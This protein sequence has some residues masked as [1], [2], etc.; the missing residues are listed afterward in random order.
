MH[1]SVNF[2]PDIAISTML[3]FGF[4]QNKA[5]FYRTKA[6]SE[7]F[8]AL[9]SATIKLKFTKAQGFSPKECH[10]V[11]SEP[12]VI[13]DILCCLICDKE[14]NHQQ[15]ILLHSAEISKAPSGL[16][17]LDSDKDNKGLQEQLLLNPSFPLQWK[18]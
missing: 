18:E 17:L 5:L 8:T 4:P 3:W 11:V 9:C 12:I 7:R 6:A 1:P 13:S 16:L 2:T 14:V 15:L 10:T